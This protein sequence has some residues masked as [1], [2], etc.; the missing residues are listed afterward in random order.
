MIKEDMDE[1]CR[2]QASIGWPNKIVN[3][4]KKSFSPNVSSYTLK[5]ELTQSVRTGR[6]TKQG[7]SDLAD[8]IKRE[9]YKTHSPGIKPYQP[10]QSGAA[11][12]RPP[13]AYFNTKVPY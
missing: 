4:E 8:D 6:Q 12:N 10:K 5:E 9:A 3:S 13:F 1:R 2:N 7:N 11:G